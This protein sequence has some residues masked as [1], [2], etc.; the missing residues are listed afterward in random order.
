MDSRSF[1][2]SGRARF[3]RWKSPSMGFDGNGLITI[4]EC[5]QFILSSVY[6]EG[7]AREEWEG[8][9]GAEFSSS[10]SSRY[11]SGSTLCLWALL[12]LFVWFDGLI[13]QIRRLSQHKGTIIDPFPLVGAALVRSLFPSLLWLAISV[14]GLIIFDFL[15]VK[16]TLSSLVTSPWKKGGDSYRVHYGHSPRSW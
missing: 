4:L 11:L 12:A 3:L 10:S 1:D 14:S 16:A 6:K 5:M 13:L 7:S 15:S 9:E 8:D 2:G